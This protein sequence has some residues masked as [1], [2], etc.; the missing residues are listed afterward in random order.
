MV[1]RCSHS[2]RLLAPFPS[3]LT[4]PPPHPGPSAQQPRPPRSPLSREGLSASSLS[5]PLHSP[6]LFILSAPSFSARA[7]A[8]TLGSRLFGTLCPFELARLHAL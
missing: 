6:R 2:P 8:N 3:P 5:A 4:A 7:P 1:Y